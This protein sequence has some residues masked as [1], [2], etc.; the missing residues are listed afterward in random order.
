MP[1]NTI[2]TSK[3]QRDGRCAY[4]RGEER[5]PLAGVSSSSARAGRAYCSFHA[6]ALDTDIHQTHQEWRD[7]LDGGALSYNAYQVARYG[8]NDVNRLIDE[9]T[10]VMEG[11]RV[12]LGRTGARN[13][14]K[15]IG[16]HRRLHLTT[17]FSE[18]V[19][20]LKKELGL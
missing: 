10:R 20:Q 2:P 4:H 12:S 16:D 1:R 5:C 19:H 13:P 15:V 11:L 3:P 8:G 6:T 9:E 18:W 17:P 14:G 7:W